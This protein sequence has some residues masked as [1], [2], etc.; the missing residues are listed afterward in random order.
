MHPIIDGVV[1][2]VGRL[3]G[4]CFCVAL[5]MLSKKAA[6]KLARNTYDGSFMWVYAKAFLYSALVALVL[7]VM[8]RGYANVQRD[9]WPGAEDGIIEQKNDLS[10]YEVTKRYA[11]YFSFAF[12]LIAS[13]AYYGIKEAQNEENEEER[14]AE[15][16][17]D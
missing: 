14:L 6:L 8:C 13:G 16:E 11:S 10:D 7:M 5:W 2:A 1:I 3:V 15:A 12:I 9:P 4:I 17:E